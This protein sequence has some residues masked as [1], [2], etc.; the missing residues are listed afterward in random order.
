[1]TASYWANNTIDIFKGVGLPTLTYGPD[2]E[3]RPNTVSASSGINPVYS[4]TYNPAGQATDV[5]FGSSSGAGDPVDFGYDSNTGRMTQ[6]KLTINST[7]THGDPTWNPNG[8][9]ESLGIT[10]PFNAS[11]AQ[12]CSYGYDDMARLAS[13]NC[14]NGTTNVWNQNFTYDPFGNITKTVP[15]GGTGLSFQPGYN[16]ANNHYTDGATYDADGNL[17]ND[18]TDHVYTWDADGHP[19]TLDSD[20]LA[21]DAL[22]HE[23]E[24]FKGGAY[25]EFAFGPSGK[26]ALMNGQTQ[27]KAFVLLPGGTQVKY[28]GSA[29]STYR[30]PDWLGSFRVGSNPNRTY[31]WG[32]AFAPFGEQY[33]PSGSPAWSFTGE[34]GTADTVADEYDFLA[35][36]LH[37]AQGRW[38]SAD[39]AG[40]GAANPDNPQSWNRYSYVSNYP[41]TSVD[42]SGLACYPIERA[43]TGSCAAFMDNG[44]NFGSNWNEFD[45]LENPIPVFGWVNGF[46]DRSQWPLFCTNA[47]RLR[48]RSDRL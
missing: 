39:R 8:T 28:A 29:I 33:A 32:I 9:L 6:Y 11:D 36:K 46:I 44:V 40:L 18:G 14:L 4:T 15:T 25:T 7:A 30:L 10:D 24:V 22:G 27:T 34:E 37:S 20:T 26:L 43:L 35:R 16:E 12:T 17:T 47:R 1:M 2:G 45:L 42:P 41:L 31:S 23:V 48:N 38:I 5:T 21:Y 3:G 19:V 13:V